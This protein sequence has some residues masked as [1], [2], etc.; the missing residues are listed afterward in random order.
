MSET[1]KPEPNIKNSK[2]KKQPMFY[3]ITQDIQHL[4]NTL[5]DDFDEVKI[6]EKYILEM[7]TMYWPNGKKNLTPLIQNKLI[8]K[9]LRC[10]PNKEKIRYQI[11]NAWKQKDK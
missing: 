11:Q 3:Q 5:W 6:S 2:K 4:D 1:K 10:M 9:I 8:G 7:L